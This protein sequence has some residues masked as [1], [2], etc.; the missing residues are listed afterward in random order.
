MLRRRYNSYRRFE[1][2]L[3]TIVDRMEVQII[4]QDLKNIDKI[5]K[6]NVWICCTVSSYALC[7]DLPLIK[8]E[9]GIMDGFLTLA[10][11]YTTYP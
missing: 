5:T 1:R 4:H 10:F 7:W 6:E 8:L 11:A 9:L 2:E 3:Y